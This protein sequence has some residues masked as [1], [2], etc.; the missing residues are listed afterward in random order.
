MHTPQRF[1][2]YEAFQCLDAQ[3]KLAGSHRPLAR[4][5]TRA[6]TRQLVLSRVFR[7]VDNPQILAATALQRRLHEAFRAVRHE[8]ERLDHHSLA[9]FSREFFPPQRSLFH[10]GL[11]GQFDFQKWRCQDEA[12]VG[13]R[14][15]VEG[16]H[17]PPMRL[18]NVNSAFRGEQVEWRQPIVS[19]RVYWPAVAPVGR[20]ILL[21]SGQ[22][23]LVGRFQFRSRRTLPDCLHHGRKRPNSSH[24]HGS[25]LSLDQL[26]GLRRPRHQFAIQTEPVGLELFPESGVRD[27]RLHAG[28]KSRLFGG[29]RK[30]RSPCSRVANT[31]ASV[32]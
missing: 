31:H 17:V 24:A 21:H 32:D 19:Q 6:Q 22:T 10:R 16:V 29:I 12:R 9:A 8:I 26:P 11:V 18:V 15:P 13:R 5:A 30:E 27:G 14:Q 4:H 28:D 25:V 7:A 1:T 3:R 20:A 2:P 23:P